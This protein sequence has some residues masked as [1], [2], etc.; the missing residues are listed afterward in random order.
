M[1]LAKDSQTL[2][3][4]QYGTDDVT[5]QIYLVTGADG[6][7]TVALVGTITADAAI[8]WDDLVTGQ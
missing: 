4:N 3:F 2:L 1:A 5:T 6:D 7:D 8:V